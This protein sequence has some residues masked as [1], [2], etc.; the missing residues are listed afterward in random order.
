MMDL[1]IGIILAAPAG[2]G[3]KTF[4]TEVP[5][6]FFVVGCNYLAFGMP[7]IPS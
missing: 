3:S 6:V 1:V 2:L 5:L 7:I 4:V